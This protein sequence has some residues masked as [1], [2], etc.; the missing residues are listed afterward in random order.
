[1]FL[2]TRGTNEDEVPSELVEFLHYIEHSTDAEADAAKSER[3]RKIHERVCKVRL[4][5]EVG[6]KYMQAWEERYYDCEEARKDGYEDGKAEGRRNLLLELIRKNREKGRS[7]EEI[8]ELL[9]VPEEVIREA[10]AHERKCVAG[11]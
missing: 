11:F 9:D 3:I 6:V 1:M 5:E 8:A 4:S 7:A 10:E 2:N